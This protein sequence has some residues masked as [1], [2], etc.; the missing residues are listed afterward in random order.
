MNPMQSSNNAM[1]M[2][3]LMQQQKGV[4]AGQMTPQ[5]MLFAQ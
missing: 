4:P 5:Q 2:N 1:L 3:T